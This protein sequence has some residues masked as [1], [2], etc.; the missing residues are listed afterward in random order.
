MKKYN[1]CHIIRKNLFICGF[2]FF[3]LSVSMFFTSFSALADV[4]AEVSKLSVTEG[5]I[6]DFII[7]SS[8]SS[9]TEPNIIPLQKN[10][11]IKGRSKSAQTSFINGKVSTFTE[12]RYTISP[13]QA[14][15]LTIPA[16]SVG[17]E[18]TAPI[19]VVV[20]KATASA[21][22]KT[23]ANVQ[24][25]APLSAS[26]ASAASG[27]DVFIESAVN[28]KKVY[29]GSQ[30]LYVV[31]L[32]SATQIERGTWPNPSVSDAIVERIGDDLTSQNTRAGKTYNIIE[33][34]YAIFPEKAGEFKV[35]VSEFTGSVLTSGLSANIVQVGFGALNA[36][37]NPSEPVKVRSNEITVQVLPKPA[38]AKGK[39]L[40][41]Y[42][43]S[44]TLTLK[45]NSR[46]YKANEAIEAVLELKASG[47]AV[48]LLPD[49]DLPAISGV[50][51]YPS[52]SEKTNGVDKSGV[53]GKITKTFVLI[54]QKAGVYTIPSVTMDWWNLTKQSNDTAATKAETFTVQ[55]A[56]IVEEETQNSDDEK[57]EVI[58]K[59][60]E[61]NS[62]LQEQTDNDIFRMQRIAIFGFAVLLAVT[63]FVFI[64]RKKNTSQ[65]T[66]AEP[67]EVKVTLKVLEKELAS[68]DVDAKKMSEMLVA[69]ARKYFNDE[70]IFNISQIGERLRND[71]LTEELQELNHSIYSRDSGNFDG[72]LLLKALK[73]ALNAK[74]QREK[75]VKPVP[76]LYP[77]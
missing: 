43:M 46:G 55:K 68:Q 62:N 50:R 31:R 11:I 65:D 42:N 70:A 20:S 39:W 9:N 72:Q 10:F 18:K 64:R 32:F 4:T 23:A 35:P 36:F 49:I 59:K 5:G 67:E 1:V 24:Q 58:P 74:K 33:R 8:S 77:E 53:V 71:S 61:A 52:K 38:Q 41:A 66:A 47:L 12:W 27:V 57:Q 40:P 25:Q 34:R 14:G 51:I 19:N 37:L 22:G 54:P 3:F 73:E 16:I 17:S 6:L 13:K 21:G 60:K 26:A 48:A 75:E 76:D 30:I 2:S 28:T 29:E 44:L 63:V 56:D 15:R 45:P 69:W 7:R